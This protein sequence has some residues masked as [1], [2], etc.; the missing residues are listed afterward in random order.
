MRVDVL[1]RARKALSA[2]PAEFDTWA[3]A[4][5]F[6]RAA[7]P[8]S[9]QPLI[10]ERA[11]YIFRRLAN[12]KVTW[13]YDPK[14]REDFTAA[15]PPPFIGSNPPE[16]W[17]QIRCPILFL[18]PEGGGNGLRVD[19]C[20]PLLRYGNRSRFVEVPNSKHWIHEENLDGFL[21]AITPFF[22]ESFR[23]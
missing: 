3:E 19:E 17:E 21:Q 20:Q 9:V 1:P 2:V 18:V 16:V 8:A 14:A 15:E 11:P 7:Q 23:R 12:G 6:D 5:A 10:A 4:V 22:G 13:K